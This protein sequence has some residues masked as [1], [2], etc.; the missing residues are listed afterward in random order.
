MLK[1]I[2][3]NFLILLALVLTFT[4]TLALFCFN[5]GT[6][7]AIEMAS[8]A[9][10][11]ALNDEI[12]N[13]SP[14]RADDIFEILEGAR[15]QTDGD[16]FLMYSISLKDGAFKTIAD[17]DIFPC[18]N[19]LGFKVNTYSLYSFNLFF[20]DATGG[21]HKTYSMLIYTEPTKANGS[22]YCVSTY[23]RSYS[24]N[25]SLLLY[26]D[27]Y[28]TETNRLFD[29]NESDLEKSV[30]PFGYTQI[31]RQTYT[32]GVSLIGEK[33]TGNNFNI[34]IAN[35]ND[36]YQNVFLEF[37][38]RY[39]WCS[40]Q[41]VFNIE[42]DTVSNE[43]NPL[44]S[45]TRSCYYMYKRLCETNSPSWDE[46]M[47]KTNGY[48]LEVI[49]NYETKNI[50]VEYLVPIENTPFATT[51]S[52]DI[53]VRFVDTLTNEQVYSALCVENVDVYKSQGYE[54]QYDSATGKYKAYYLPDVW[55][56]GITVGG[57]YE[58]YFLD[59]NKSY[60][61]Y[62]HPFVNAGIMDNA[63][64]EW[65]YNQMIVKYPEIDE[66]PMEDL[67]GYFGF[68]AIPSEY[69]LAELWQYMFH[70]STTNTYGMIGLFQYESLLSYESYQKLLG[71]YQYTWLERAW[72]GIAGF[73]SGSSYSAKYYMIYGE[74]DVD[75][76][77]AENNGQTPDD[78][79]SAIKEDVDNFFDN[80]GDKINSLFQGNNTVKTLI[81]ILIVT[82][83]VILVVKII[84]TIKG[85]KQ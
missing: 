34:I 37:S 40:N 75:G 21:K 77:A 25:Q 33:S 45:D 59:L 55:I 62:F 2:K 32:E 7:P 82:I 1:I 80:V 9:E 11:Y 39:V 43:D 63:L 22:E 73:V 26:K 4:G 35:I 6:Q 3:K 71:D 67:H 56:R 52:K 31:S 24:A 42:Y 79:Q 10:A 84:Q 66:I 12:T 36:Y 61:D 46:L 17:K 29:Y 72:S 20:L 13:S 49:N 16:T 64:F 70:G 50:T 18:A 74:S 54:F 76:L 65:Y 51:V 8:A 44:R 5:T 57:N 14:N 68:L 38:Y 53:S 48:C 78:T 27:I 23:T 15:V 30:I 47:T 41:N 69:S 83:L 60:Y 85:N 19:G 28:H 81:I 58:D